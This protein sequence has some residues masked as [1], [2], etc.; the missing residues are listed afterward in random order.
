MKTIVII[1]AR[2]DS[3]RVPGKPLKKISGQIIIRH[4]FFSTY[5]SDIP[6]KV[7]VASRDPEILWQ[8][9]TGRMKG[10]QN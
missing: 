8:V 6:N 1:P 4:C 2:M 3:E 10:L 5:N 7:Y 9:C